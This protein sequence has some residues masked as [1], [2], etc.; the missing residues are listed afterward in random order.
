MLIDAPPEPRAILHRLRE[1]GL[2]LVALLTTH[3]H[4]DHV[5]GI[6]EVVAHAHD[7]LAAPAAGVPVHIHDADRHMLLDPV[8]TGG[9]LAQM[10]DMENLA[11]RRPRSCSASTTA[12]R[13]RGRA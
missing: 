7:G 2:K 8:G 12:R 10:L 1:N 13:C 3:G 9:T 6:G 11:C 5:G 4:V